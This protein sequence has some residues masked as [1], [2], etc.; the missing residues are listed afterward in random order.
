VTIDGHRESDEL[1]IM[2]ENIVKNE[3]LIEAGSINWTLPDQLVAN[4]QQ[5]P[6]E[7]TPKAAPEKV[8]PST[9]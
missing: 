5:V 8:K 4:K 1:A 7:A 6:S 9:P 2:I 3:P